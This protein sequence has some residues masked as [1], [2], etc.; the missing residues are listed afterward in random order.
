MSVLSHEPEF[1]SLPLEQLVSLFYD[2]LRLLAARRLAGERNAQSPQPTSLTNEAVL[3]LMGRGV[4]ATFASR[5]H[6]F[7]SASEAMRRVLV[8]AAR[9][10][11][12]LKRG[13]GMTRLDVATEQLPARDAE[14]EIL[15][16]DELLGL[17]EDC[18]ADAA[19]LLRLRYFGGFTIAEA[20]EAMGLPPRTAER[21]WAYA[22]AWVGRQL[23]RSDTRGA[24]STAVSPR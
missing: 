11:Q 23:L 19:A 7:A 1:A 18:D 13:G 3:R 24:A 21:R 17:L 16:V 6:F 2:E 5:G 12:S 20:A 4:N 8:D 14:Q 22:R 9:R 10:R 15:M